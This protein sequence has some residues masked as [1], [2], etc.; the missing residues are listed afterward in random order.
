MEIVGLEPR[1]SDLAR[2]ILVA[3]SSRPLDARVQK[4]MWDALSAAGIAE[5]ADD[6][7]A[8]EPDRQWHAAPGAPPTA[9]GATARRRG[10]RAAPA[11]AR[12]S[13]HRV[14][15]RGRLVH[16]GRD[17]DRWRRMARAPR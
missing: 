10:N 7:A 15:P 2:G 3:R 6:D 16:E 13:G 9:A 5:K 1:R 17:G 12:G 4:E 8:D 14:R 11:G